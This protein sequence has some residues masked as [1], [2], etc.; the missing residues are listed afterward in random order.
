[1][2]LVLN[3]LRTFDDIQPTTVTRK[4]R[5]LICLALFLFAFAI[6]TLTWQDN[7][8]DALKVQTSVTHRYKESARQLVNGEFKTFLT[9]VPRLGHPPGYPIVLAAIFKTVGESDTF[10][11]FLQIT[12]DSV[13]V[14]VLFLISLELFSL[15]VSLIA[16]VLAGLSPQ[17][18]Y[19]SVL[20]LPDSLIVLPILLAIY[21]VVK[22]RKQFKWTQLFLAGLLIGA[23]CWLRAN[24]M[25][26]PLFAGLAATLTVTKNRRRSAMAAVV[27]GAIVAIAP[28][29]IKNAI[30]FHTFIPLSLGSG[31]T[32][33]EGLADYDPK[34]TL[35][36]PS[37]DLGLTRQ[38]AQWYGRPDYAD[39]LFGVEGIQ[40]DRMRVRR[41]LK[42]IAEHPLWFASVMGRRALAST[43]LD[44]V[45]VLRPEAPY[46]NSSG[47]SSWTWTKWPRSWF[48]TG[49]K[50]PHTT[51]RGLPEV[52]DEPTK[53]FDNL[54]IR[55][56][57]DNENY[58]DQLSSEEINVA[59][60]HD[61][62]LIVP[63]K[64][65]RGRIKIKIVSGD[66]EIA[67]TIVETDEVYE[68]Q[69][70]PKK[71]VQLEFVNANNSPLRIVI[72]NNASVQPSLLLGKLELDDLGATGNTW[73][74]YVRMPLG[75]VQKL[76]TTA[77]MLPFLI[78][79]C[80]LLVWHK[81][82]D[83]LAIL[84]AVPAYYL[85]VQSALHTERRY[86][87]VIHFFF[88]VI[89]S[90]ALCWMAK[91]LADLMDKGAERA[92]RVN[93]KE[94]GQGPPSQPAN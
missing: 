58:G 8:L 70:Q 48:E 60:Y 82:V 80:A 3:T 29:T 28:V 73:M 18:A 79:G 76:F 16:A 19:F 39:N 30:V 71:N 4:Q 38:E 75:F 12:V 10:L 20:L 22:S 11:Q 40:R 54:W 72:A 1:L 26:L 15:S 9:D 67:S 64:L 51:I 25:L 32:L 84:M 65:E 53:D 35:N 62:A 14:V 31:Q 24:A 61:F 52:S 17:F 59:R 46:G 21:L 37:T 45:P 57:G 94:R 91:M 86:V 77:W 88:L 43:R 50:S 34:G 49:D 41:G 87:Y 23:S 42:T 78:V 90:V 89:V 13:S 83:E 69:S 63:I 27:A 92:K 5:I 85:I 44:P 93:S 36:I 68:A 6:R 2:L 74:R 47:V 66:K 33:L 55:V 7:W 56:I 81:R